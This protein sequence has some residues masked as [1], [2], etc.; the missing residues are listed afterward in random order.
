MWKKFEKFCR[1]LQKEKN[2]A[3]Q[4]H[5]MEQRI[6]T[7]GVVND[8][9]GEKQTNDV[10]FVRANG[11]PLTNMQAIES[12]RHEQNR[13]II[14][15][16][17][18]GSY[19]RFGNYIIIP[20]I[21][22]EL[23]MMPKIIYVKQIQKDKAIYDMK[24]MVPLFGD[25][26]FKLVASKKEV[27]L[28]LVETVRREAGDYVEV[29]EEILDNYS[30]TEDDYVP[31]SV[32]LRN[33]NIFDED[34]DDYGRR[35]FSSFDF[36]NILTRKIYLSLLS[37]ELSEIAE[38]DDK[39]SFEEMVEILKDSGEYGQRVLETFE[40]RL[41]DRPEIYDL[42]TSKEYN[43][44][45]LETLLSSL[46]IATTQ[47]DKENYETR[48][49][50]FKLLGVRNRNIEKYLEQANEKVNEQY[51][52]NIVTRA[53]KQFLQDEEEED[54]VLLEFMDKISPNKKRNE[55]RKL[56][57]PILKQG[58][59]ERKEAQRLATLD[60]STQ[61]KKEE[62]I[63]QI[64]TAKKEDKKKAST[65]AKKKL[66]PAKKVAKKSA[67]KGNS[68][69]KSKGKPKSKLK[70]KKAV[71]KPSNAKKVEKKV[72]GKLKPKKKS[73]KK[74]AGK[75]EGKKDNKKKKEYGL[76]FSRAFLEKYRSLSSLPQ[77]TVVAAPIVQQK[78]QSQTIVETIK[79]EKIQKQPEKIDFATEP[80]ES[81]KQ[82][83]KNDYG[84]KTQESETD[85]IARDYVD[86]TF[87][88]PEGSLKKG[89]AG[90][91]P[92]SPENSGEGQNN[93]NFEISKTDNSEEVQKIKKLEGQSF[94]GAE[95]QSAEKQSI[96][97][98]FKEKSE[99]STQNPQP[100]GPESGPKT[101][102]QPIQPQGTSPDE[103]FFH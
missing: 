39:E 98:Q 34:D 20:A 17:R 16:L 3:E 43:K 1:K 61:D 23:L 5:V 51:V 75:K 11:E 2:M 92:A 45:V 76:T 64:L 103:Q 26:F 27:T 100:I 33:Y 18:L 79:N 69:A 66:K 65:P 85:V 72:G 37:R 25:I 6:K 82:K 63:K 13:D 14:D 8:G 102:S 57:A 40:N 71:K 50:Y 36:T 32:I 48:E 62:A 88:A 49:I 60:L 41:K 70:T 96:V 4:E 97:D 44:A 7:P 29:Y 84:F 38:F 55:K 15:N 42:S 73:N 93:Q 81:G 101:D 31:L 59:E 99:F 83:L 35:M 90:E 56:D 46:D 87:G 30:M 67:K 94:F 22:E 47:A 52:S 21:R 89:Q 80:Q 10:K 53:T 74:A 24:S 12:C 95:E 54:L 68:K 9:D 91:K 28:Y 58:L 77:Q 78:S 86:F 19:D